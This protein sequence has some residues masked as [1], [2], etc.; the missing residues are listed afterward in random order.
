MKSGK[1]ASLPELSPN[2]CVRLALF[3]LGTA[4]A[5]ASLIGCAS[6]SEPLE[7]KPPVAATITD[8]AASQ[9]ANEVVLTFTL[10]T[11]TVDRRPLKEPLAIEIYRGVG[12]PGADSRSHMTLVATIPAG[13]ADQYAVHGQ[14][15][16]IDLLNADV[17]GSRDSVG[18]NYAVRTRASVKKDSEPSNFAYLLLRPALEPV[19]DLK[20]DVTQSAVVLTWTPPAKTIAGSAPPITGYRVYRTET[21]E[22]AT[23]EAKPESKPVTVKIGETQMPSF[24][25]TQ[26]DFGRTYQYSVKSVI[27][28]GL[29]ALESADSN[30]LTITP[31][32][33][34]PPAAPQGLVATLVPRQGDVAAHLELSWAINAETDLAGYNI[35][36]SEGADTPGTRV[37]T[38]LL[39]TP[40]FRDMNAQPGHRYSYTVTAVDRA[41]N[42]S[43]A[44]AAVSGGVPA[45]NGPTP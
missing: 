45:E 35:Y 8:L 3:L 39:L 36:R 5:G 10:P 28:S 27:G 20:A 42:E 31:K 13:E 38:D 24:E 4:L 44:S 21:A 17:F 29:E 12:A 11:E 41:G 22:P 23:S 1:G 30:V 33:T 37:N 32:D 16:Y 9:N 40:S 15:R 14:V 34:F 25:D 2:P 43:A 26:F 19:S 7:R 18:A 6:P